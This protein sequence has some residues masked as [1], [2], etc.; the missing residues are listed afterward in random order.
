MGTGKEKSSKEKSG[1][2]RNGKEKTAKEVNAKREKTA[3]EKTTKESKS[4]EL[5]GKEKSGKE[6]KGKEKNNKE[7]NG[8]EKRGKEKKGKE[9][10]AK[11]K[12]GKENKGKEK[13]NKRPCPKEATTIKPNSWSSYVNNWDGGVSYSTS[14]RPIVGIYSVHHNGKEDRL[15][16]FQNA[17]I[18][19]KSITSRITNYLNN[20]DGAVHYTCPGNQAITGFYSYH[21]NGK[22][23]RRWRVRCS[24]FANIKIAHGAWSQWQNGWDSP[25]NAK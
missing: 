6:K 11:E 17:N 12:K 23:D 15:W 20:W 7:K 13:E 16:K 9:G 25:L 4:K 3:K 8:K 5:K 18:G 2:E 1:K 19:A 14:N 10:K 21:D 24:G 22:E